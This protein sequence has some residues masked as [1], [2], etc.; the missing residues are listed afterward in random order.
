MSIVIDKEFESLIPPLTEEEFAK[1]ENLILEYG[2]LDALK[3]WE[4]PY[5]PIEEFDSAYDIQEAANPVILF[6]NPVL[7]DGHNRYKICQKHNIPF[8]VTSVEFEDRDAVKQFIIE[9]QL[10]RRNVDLMTRYQLSKQYENIERE[11]AKQRHGARTDLVPTLAQSNFGKVRDKMAS[12][13]GISHGTYDKLKAIDNS[14]NQDIIDKVRNQEISINQGYRNV[15]NIPPTPP[16]VNPT[17]EAEKRHEQFEQA[18]EEKTV[19]FNDA[20][21]DKYDINTIARTMA[22]ELESAMIKLLNIDRLGSVD[23]EN[24][25]KVERTESAKSNFKRQIKDCIK[26]LMHIERILHDW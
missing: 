10:G 2:C 1:L 19:S 18:K 3:V 8:K 24:I 22:T 20:R 11:K 12:M 14:G 17:K 26:L 6:H 25:L 4:E 21:Q 16:K 5:S 23:I 7:V 15:M 9:N 13:L